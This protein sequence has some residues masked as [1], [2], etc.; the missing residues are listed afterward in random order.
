[1]TQ[2]SLL[3][4]PYFAIFLRIM[5]FSSLKITILLLGS[6]GCASMTRPQVQSNGAASPWWGGCFFRLLSF[7]QSVQVGSLATVLPVA[8]LL[9]HFAQPDQ[10]VESPFDRGAGE[11]QICR[12]SADGIPA[13]TIPVSAVMEV[14]AHHFRPR[15]QVPVP[16]DIIKKAH[17]FTPP[18]LC[19]S[20]SGPCPDSRAE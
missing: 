4:R 19:Y 12:N 11:A 18:R 20:R 16:I 13:L 10:I 1:M 7:S 9:L 3:I 17:P 15:R 8:G 5:C 2:V 6:S 14:Q